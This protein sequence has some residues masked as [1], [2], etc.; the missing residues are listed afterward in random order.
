MPTTEEVQH[1]KLKGMKRSE[2]AKELGCSPYLVAYHLRKNS[3]SSVLL[4]KLSTFKSANVDR[5]N[6][7]RVKTSGET[8]GVA[9]IYNKFP[10]PTCY[11][12]GDSIDLKD[13][14]SYTLDH[15]IPVSRG[16]TN[17]LDNL[18]LASVLANQ[19]KWNMTLDE[20]LDMCEKIL[21]HNGRI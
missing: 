11:L 10:E 12:T 15:V 16:G 9:Q 17:S 2:I 7:S 6:R 3:G 14:S 20:L 18:Q 13:G 8:F 5:K 21:K 1:L 4:N 19:M